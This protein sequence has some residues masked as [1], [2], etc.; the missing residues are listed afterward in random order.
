MTAT[1]GIRQ[2]RRASVAWLAVLALL[3]NALLPASLTA[4]A[5]GK[6]RAAG[7]GWCGSGLADHQP[8]KDAAP[9]VC[10]HCILCS[11][12]SG[13]PSPVGTDVEMPSLVVI[14]TRGVIAS[15]GP[16]PSSAYSPAQPRGPPVGSRI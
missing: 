9:A 6:S 11:T 12:A 3:I 5:A 1:I 16:P 13:F 4:T 10:D 14:A 7:S 2:Q 8:V 15:A